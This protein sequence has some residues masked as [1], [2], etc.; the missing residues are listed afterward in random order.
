MIARSTIAPITPITITRFW[1]SAG[2]AKKVKIIRN[3]KM[4][5]TESDFSI[6]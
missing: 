3:T 2:T 5:S 4:L 1:Y 6:R